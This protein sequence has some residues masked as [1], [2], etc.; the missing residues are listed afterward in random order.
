[1]RWMILCIVVCCLSAVADTAIAGSCFR[2]HAGSGRTVHTVFACTVCHLAD[3]RTLSAPDEAIRQAAGCAVCHPGRERIFSQA[4]TTRLAEQRFVER[5]F[6]RV[7]SGFFGKNCASCHVSGCRDCHG[8][9]WELKKPSVADCQNCHRGYYTGWDYTGRAPREDN[10]RYQRGV[11]EKGETWLKMLPD[12]HYQAGMTCGSCHGMTSLMEGKR[13]S[14][15][16][17]DC[18]RP[19]PTVLEH[20]IA[21]HMERLECYACHSAWA[22]QEYGTFFLRFR[23]RSQKEEFDLKPG[24]HPEYLRS[25]YLKTQ[26]APPLG[27]N[28]AGRVSPIRPQFIA[29][30]TDIQQARLRGGD[31]RL[32]VA[33]WRAFFP[34]TVQRGSVTC[35][36]C[37]DN[38]R[39]F[40][41]EPASQRIY[42]TAQDGLGLDSFWL[43]EGQRLVNGSFFSAGRYRQM[44]S[45]ANPVYARD[46]VKKWNNILKRVDASSR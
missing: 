25:A 1:M 45:T 32:L 35:E 2:C 36:G 22:P 46:S 34:H 26:D 44:S 5:S 41:L 21:A 9:P 6:A 12:V 40:L 43:Q 8:T 42:R 3:G 30:S 28:G 15:G 14:K 4:M 38:P 39:R 13:S 10:M 18:H 17:R 16:C 24:P 11:A 19:D 7:D 20:G 31:N 27:I 37:H 23:D 29:Y 33:E